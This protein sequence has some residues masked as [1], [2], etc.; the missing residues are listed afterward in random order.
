MDLRPFSR[1]RV[2]GALFLGLL[3]LTAGCSDISQ[4]PP[5]V[6]SSESP[7]Q[8][9]PSMTATPATPT[10]EPSPSPSPVRYPWGATEED[11]QA[12]IA[13]VATWTLEEAAG[14]VLIVTFNGTAAPVDLI[15][16]LHLG[17]LIL[18]G[19]NVSSLAQVQ[20]LSAD[21]MAAGVRLI[22][23]DN[24]GGLVQRM[25]APVWTTFPAFCHAGDAQRPIVH[26]AMEAM[27]LE[28]RA[29]G[30]NYTFAPVAD[31]TAPG[32]VTIKS[33]AASSDPQEVA[34][35]V[36]Q[37][38]HGFMSGGVISSIK[39]FPGHG[40]L[41]VDSH[42]SLPIL[43]ANEAELEAHDL[44]PFQAGIDAG[45]PTVMM[46]HIAVEAWDPG[47]AASLSPAAYQHL[48]E[49][50]G[51][52]GVAITDGLDMGALTNQYSSDEIAVLAL[53]AG[54]DLLLGPVDPRLAHRGIVE[55]V[56]DGRLSRDRLN[57]A[58]GRVAALAQWQER[59]AQESDAA[60]GELSDE[61]VR[62][63]AQLDAADA[64][65]Q[66]TGSCS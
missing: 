54:A 46:G 55:A 49:D 35:A 66:T 58:A 20:Q 24:E 45:A 47:V 29:S 9:A 43:D 37:A 63:P 11:V 48:R 39:H 22:S 6:P 61:V 62:S 17:G 50:L 51:F 23:V 4:P 30:V 38:I 18:M 44:P 14:T 10:P 7:S 19:R 1:I 40:S 8:S 5:D 31:V 26:H 60:H 3:L 15:T 41:T 12:A 52:T 36:D 64:L 56:N 13:E 25:K 28:L 42:E 59:L 21:A 2:V 27:A 34:A 32:D 33:R 16:E 65:A 57:E 53:D